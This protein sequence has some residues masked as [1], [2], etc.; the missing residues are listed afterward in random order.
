MHLDCSVWMLA[1]PRS[2]AQLPNLSRGKPTLGIAT[3]YW[4]VGTAVQGHDLKQKK[5][6][7]TVHG[8]NYS[9]LIVSHL[10]LKIRLL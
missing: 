3:L 9:I 5:K 2:V 8:H 6:G 10:N 4:A 1:S 7:S